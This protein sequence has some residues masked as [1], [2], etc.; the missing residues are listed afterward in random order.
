MGEISQPVK[1]TYGWH[2]IEVTKINPA[3]TQTFAKAK[4]QIQQTLL[5]QA[6]QAAWQ[7][8]LDQA[9]KDAHVKYA[10]GYDPVQARGRGQRQPHAGACVSPS[11]SASK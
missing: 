11:P 7:K 6:Q 3:T 4:T 5:S 8:W 10:A 9:T 2:V 1:S